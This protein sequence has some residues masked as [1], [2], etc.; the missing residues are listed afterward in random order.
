MGTIGIG[1][2]RLLLR[3]IGEIKTSGIERMRLL[4][5]DS[6]TKCVQSGLGQRV[7]KVRT[8]SKGG[9]LRYST[10]STLKQER[11]G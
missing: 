8:S 5:Q 1:S 6:L 10:K 11:S 3:R 2:R 9:I 4:R 7:G